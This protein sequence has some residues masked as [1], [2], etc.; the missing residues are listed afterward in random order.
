MFLDLAVSFSPPSDFFF[1]RYRQT[2]V[3]RTEF[4]EEKETVFLTNK[5]SMRYIISLGFPQT[6]Y[7][8]KE[9]SQQHPAAKKQVKNG[10]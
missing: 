4:L 9:V 3:R 8:P 5:F 6:I 7:E 2:V 1:A 10:L